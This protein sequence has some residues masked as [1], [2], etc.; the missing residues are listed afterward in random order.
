MQQDD[1]TLWESL[2]L[3]TLW[4]Q[5]IIYYFGIRALAGPHDRPER[6]P[7]ST[8][9]QPALA[10]ATS[11]AVASTLTG[12][13]EV[14]M[15]GNGARPGERRKRG[16]NT[17]CSLRRTRNADGPLLRA[18]RILRGEFTQHFLHHIVLNTQH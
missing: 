7:A 12:E 13:R 14:C 11:S 9:G 1:K 8:R 16:E 17:R 10:R 6:T 15:A 3:F 4:S 2:F 18:R 5:I